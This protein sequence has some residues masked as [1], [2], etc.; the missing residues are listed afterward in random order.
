MEEHPPST[1][2]RTRAASPPGYPAALPVLFVIAALLSVWKPTEWYAIAAALPAALLAAALPGRNRVRWIRAGGAAALAALSLRHLLLVDQAWGGVAVVLAVGV[3][4]WLTFTSDR[5][6]VSL[7]LLLPLGIFLAGV[8]GLEQRLFNAWP[9]SWLTVGVTICCFLLL[10]RLTE[11]RGSPW[12]FR[13]AAAVALVLGELFFALL[14]WPTTPAVGG[15]VLAL[16]ATSA[17]VLLDAGTVRPLRRL[18]LLSAL[19]VLLIVTAR[20]S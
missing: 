12:T 10:A 9:L 13:G 11:H 2:P 5:T 7:T 18:T 20:W 17:L 3:L 15:A 4:L 8:V 1:L 16:A 19:T 6:E 14:F